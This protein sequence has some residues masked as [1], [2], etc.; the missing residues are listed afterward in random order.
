MLRP[1]DPTTLSP[2]TLKRLQ[3]QANTPGCHPSIWAAAV[4]ASV[5]PAPRIRVIAR[6]DPDGNPVFWGV[7][8]EVDPGDILI[9]TDG[10]R[11]WPA[12]V[13]AT[14]DTLITARDAHGQWLFSRRGPSAGHI[15]G[16]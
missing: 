1:D 3:E 15:A 11:D 8:D 7:L 14:T 9:L 2:A 4:L 12:R 13:S 10:I 16:H 6:P 5:P